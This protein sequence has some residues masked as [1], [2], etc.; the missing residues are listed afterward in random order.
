VVYNHLLRQCSLL[1][2]QHNGKPPP[3]RLFLFGFS[4]P[5]PAPTVCICA[6][7]CMWL[8]LAAFLLAGLIVAITGS[9]VI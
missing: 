7:G 1:H 4:L 8:S 5:L 3:G 9:R 2:E 6:R